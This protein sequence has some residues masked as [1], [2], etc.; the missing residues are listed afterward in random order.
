MANRDIK[1]ENTLLARRSP[2]VLKLCDFGYSK[3]LHAPGTPLQTAAGRLVAPGLQACGALDPED[4]R[5]AWSL[6]A[7][8]P[9]ATPAQD[10][11]LQSAPGT[12]VGT[13]AYLAPEIILNAQGH[14]Y[15]GKVRPPAPAPARPGRQ[16]ALCQ[17]PSPC[18]L[19]TSRA[20]PLPHL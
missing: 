18:L 15:D 5:A 4:E 17:R 19:P 11:N 20:H 9:S 14:K 12:R 1:L 7:A 16:A 8:Q 3:V 10:E 13:T 2:P 6:H